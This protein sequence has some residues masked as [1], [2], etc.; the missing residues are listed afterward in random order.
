MKLNPHILKPKQKFKCV[1]IHHVINELFWGF[2]Q[3]CRFL[4]GVFQFASVKYYLRYLFE[5]PST[6]SIMSRLF[7]GSYKYKYDVLNFL[8][9]GLRDDE[10]PE[11][12]FSFTFV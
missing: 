4:T 5:S 3:S 7:K 2:G 1:K 6:N 12:C 8:N 10:I 9:F 11:Q